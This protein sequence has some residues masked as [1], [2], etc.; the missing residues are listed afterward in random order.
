[1]EPLPLGPQ[2]A[3]AEDVKV[4]LHSVKVLFVAAAHNSKCSVNRAGLSAGNRGIYKAN[5]FFFQFLIASLGLYGS[6]RAHIAYKSAFLD[7]RSNA[8]FVEEDRLHDR[9]AGNHCDDHFTLLTDFRIGRLNASVRDDV[10]YRFLI[11][12]RANNFHTGLQQILGHRSSH[13]PES[14]KS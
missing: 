7:R 12:I 11:E 6:N 8:A 1:M 9:A 5:A 4:R 2:R 3:V 10:S 13:N 14:D